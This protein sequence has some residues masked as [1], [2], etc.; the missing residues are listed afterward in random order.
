MTAKEMGGEKIMLGPHV[1]CGWR[2]AGVACDDVLTVT[3]VPCG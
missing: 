2:V 1:V 3:L